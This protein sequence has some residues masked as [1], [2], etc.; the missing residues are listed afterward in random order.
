MKVPC[1]GFDLDESVFNVDKNSKQVK[2]NSPISYDYMPEG[3]PSKSIGAVTLM[4]EQ[5]VS[6]FTN[7]GGGLMR[8]VAPVVLEFADG[9][10]LTVVWDGVSYDTVATMIQGQYPA[11]GNLGLAGIGDVTD[12]PFVYFNIGGPAWATADTAASHTIKVTA[13]KTVYN[14]M[15][16]N[17]LPKAGE[18]YGV[19]KKD[20][21]VTAYVFPSLAPQV[22]MNKAIDDFIAGKASITWGETKIIYA[23]RPSDTEIH[24][25]KTNNPTMYY[26]YVASKALD[27][28][29]YNETLRKP[30]QSESSMSG[31][32]L[33]DYD[34]PSIG[35]IG[36][37]ASID[38]N[39]SANNHV[40]F[41][42]WAS[43]Y[44]NGIAIKSSDSSKVFKITV[45]DSGTIKATEV[46]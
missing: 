42:T 24:V 37:R 6:P 16:A 32:Q 44:N 25:V 28:I 38:S 2:L 31:I 27:G 39:N 13:T 18:G 1:G 20:E 41:G 23:E 3:Y 46:T 30:I 21:I 19:V 43:I 40:S 29:Y 15:D 9:D 45:D 8:A 11:F 12:Y 34:D 5:E 35:S 14:T 26:K 17:M 4:E 10:K 36:I 33:R 22:E 7:A